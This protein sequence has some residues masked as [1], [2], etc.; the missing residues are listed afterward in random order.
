MIVVAVPH[1]FRCEEMVVADGGDPD[2]EAAGNI[3]H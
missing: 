2:A 1:R 3:W